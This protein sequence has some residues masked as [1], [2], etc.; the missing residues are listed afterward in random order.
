MMIILFILPELDPCSGAAR[1]GAESPPYRLTGNDCFAVPFPFFSYLKEGAHAISVDS[2]TKAPG[3]FSFTPFPSSIPLLGLSPRAAW[4]KLNVEN[5]GTE[6][7]RAYLR[8]ADA[9]VTDMTF[10]HIRPDTVIAC[11]T[12]TLRPFNKRDIKDREFIFRCIFPP[13][14]IS[15]IYLRL[16][17]ASWLD[18]PVS[19]VDEKS[20]FKK[21]RT[22][23]LVSGLV[24]GILCFFGFGGLILSFIYRDSNL[25]NF[26]IFI[27]LYGILLA[28]GDGIF[29]M[30]CWPESPRLQNAAYFFFS[31]L[32]L[33]S[34][35]FFF[36][37]FLK[38][39]Q[40][41]HRIMAGGYVIVAVLTATLVISL[42]GALNV[43]IPMLNILAMITMAY[44][45]CAALATFSHHDLA[46]R[47]CFFIWCVFL[48]SIITRFA[49]FSLAL[50]V[51]PSFAR[52]LHNGYQYHGAIVVV[53]LMISGA[54]GYRL[55]L[56]EKARHA[57]VLQTAA[58][59]R[60]ALELKLSALQARVQP[61]F[62]FNT[63]DTIASVIPVDA[64][65]AEGALIELSEFYR[66]TLRFASRSMT[67]LWEEVDLIERY[68]SLEKM[69]R[70]GRLDFS[71]AIDECTRGISLPPMS[72]QV[73]V[74]NSLKHGIYP[75]TGGGS[76]RV[77]SRGNG[78]KC[79]IVVDDTGIGIR[80]RTNDG[81]MGIVNLRFRFDL[82]YRGNYSMVIIEKQ[83]STHSDETGVTTIIEIPFQPAVTPVSD[84]V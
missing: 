17:A 33:N 76:I 59:Q 80:E 13:K 45:L 4:V 70:G 61:Q 74:E 42:T 51:A 66:M 1:H 60:Q 83:P 6:K 43:S 28:V 48:L 25:R 82:V 65:R 40:S 19:M 62:L 49:I 84:M 16:T 55:R 72:L 21:E 8:F 18:L 35:L 32:S 39:D 67:F 15:T 14:S 53:A 31:I 26:A 64:R 11:T 46:S 50:P 7:V 78:G 79:T 75:K 52:V 41:S 22:D 37:Y 44:I 63:L 54:I 5:P 20:F 12:G 23:Q 57:T 9:S 2:L 34:G 29:Y 27:F 71:I 56:I 36:L 77:T 38:A 69:K 24:F 47:F 68:L 58:L 73:L 81:G 10:Y 3:A 30:Y